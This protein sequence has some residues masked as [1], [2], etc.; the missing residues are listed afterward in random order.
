MSE[1]NGETHSENDL[2]LHGGWNHIY[3]YVYGRVAS[4]KTFIYGI[5]HLEDLL[6]R[7]IG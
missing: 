1:T 7:V 6:I 5:T 3:V 4:S 2:K